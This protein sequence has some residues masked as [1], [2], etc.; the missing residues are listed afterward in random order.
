MIEQRPSDGLNLQNPLGA[1]PLKEYL[2]VARRRRWWVI[3]VAIAM[4]VGATVMGMRLPNVYRA[5]TVILVDPQKVPDNYVPTTVSSTVSD[6]LTTIRQIALSPTRLEELIQRL[7]LDRRPEAPRDRQR[8]I[9]KVQKSITIEV[10]DSGGQRLS[11]FKICFF[12]TNP[13]D[14]AIVANQLAA[15]VIRDNLRAR[16]QQFTG[17]AEFLDTE[18]NNVKQQLETKEKEVQRIKSQNITDLPESKQYHLEALNGLRDQLRVSQDRLNQLQ[19]N[20]AYLQTTMTESAPTVDLDGAN[21]APSISP[22]EREIQRLETQLSELQARYGPSYPDIRKLQSEISDLKAK[23]AQDTSATAVRAE[24]QPTITRKIAHNPVLEAELNKIDGEIAKETRLQA[25]LQPQIDLHLSKLQRV[26]VF[27]LQLSDQAR[28]Y[29]Q[30]NAH[31]NQLLN[32]KLSATMAKELD[33]QQQGERFIILDR[34]TVPSR[35]Y[36]PNR[37]LIMLAGLLGGLLG[38]FGLAVLVEMSDESVR[39]EREA[40]QIVGKNV[41]AAIPVIRLPSELRARRLRAVG[42]ITGTALGAA[43]LAIGASYLLRLVS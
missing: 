14:S 29:E 15:L 30:L 24:V 17:T 34:A 39:N 5:E 4:F 28:D 40:S 37:L 13:E 10:G 19:Q 3:L 36:A 18:L 7:Q 42:M 21:A 16:E 25:Q 33:A 31:Y 26:P 9:Q 11:S 38:G 32:K 43:V 35:P 27:E 41:L 2:D 20:K 1:H 8:L 12:S 6:R 22:Y 23:A